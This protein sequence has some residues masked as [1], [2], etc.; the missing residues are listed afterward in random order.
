MSGLVS[1]SSWNPSKIVGSLVYFSLVFSSKSDQAL[2]CSSVNVVFSPS[3]LINNLEAICSSLTH[4]ISNRLSLHWAASQILRT[5]FVVNKDAVT[6]HLM[7]LSLLF[8]SFFSLWDP[9][10]NNTF[11]ASAM[12]QFEGKV[13]LDFQRLQ[14]DCWLSWTFIDFTDICSFNWGVFHL[15]ASPLLLS[16][17]F[18]C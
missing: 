11:S 12:D 15:W 9:F 13:W 14:L 17:I 18:L 4:M 2:L 5:L 8:F 7:L 6:E 1:V 10:G 16:H 3:E